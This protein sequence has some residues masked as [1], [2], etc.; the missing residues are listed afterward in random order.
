MQNLSPLALKLSEKIEDDRRVYCKNAKF[1]K[2]PIGKDR[3]CITDF[4]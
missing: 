4:Q 3:Q 1:L 2:T